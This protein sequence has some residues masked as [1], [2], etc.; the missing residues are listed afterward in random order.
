MAPLC[1]VHREPG[2]ARV[3]AIFRDEAEDSFYFMNNTKIKTPDF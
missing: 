2:E 1:V 3:K